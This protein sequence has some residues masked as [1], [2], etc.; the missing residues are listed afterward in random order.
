M[1]VLPNSSSD[2]HETLLSALLLHMHK[3]MDTSFKGDAASLTPFS[4]KFIL[5]TGAFY[6]GKVLEDPLKKSFEKASFDQCVVYLRKV[7][8]WST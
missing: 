2:K 5:S 4:S 3:S 1:N 7:E 6:K 8:V